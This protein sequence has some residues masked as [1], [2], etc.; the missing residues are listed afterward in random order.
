[1][2]TWSLTSKVERTNLYLSIAKVVNATCKD[3][4][5]KDEREEIIEAIFKA[6]KK[7]YDIHIMQMAGLISKLS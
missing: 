1:M 3:K 4:L 5:T 2:S 7:Y 6:N